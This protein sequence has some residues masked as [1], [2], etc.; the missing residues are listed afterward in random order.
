MTSFHWT[1]PYCDRDTTITGTVATG[2]FGLTMNNADGDRWFSYQLIVCPSLNCR[3]FTLTLFMFEYLHSEG[4]KVGKHLETWNLIPPSNA[5][6]FP[7]YVPKAIR[8]DY[9]E[10]CKIRDLSPKASATLSRRCLQ[11]MIRDFWGIVKPR[12]IDEIEALKEK[13]D[14]LTWEAIDSTRKIG[15][16]GAH[17]EKDINLIVDVD[18]NEANLLIWL[19]ELL[20][21][22]WYITRQERQERLL[23]IVKAKDAK[24]AAKGP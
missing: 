21:K 19:I 8:D 11:G 1:C 24:D 22:D 4:W 13:T 5:K 12:L 16:V 23:A 18:A 7:D 17:M 14:A 3:R 9:V 10:A 2:S 6:V 15:N 20:V